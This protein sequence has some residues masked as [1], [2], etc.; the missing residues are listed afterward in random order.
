MYDLLLNIHRSSWYRYVAFVVLIL[1]SSCFGFN[2]DK[3]NKEKSKD[4]EPVNFTL[5]QI[6]KR[7]TLIALVNN[8]STSYFLY[9][10]HPRGFQYDL[11][12]RFA[13][14]VGVKL[15]LKIVNNVGDAIKML[16]NGEGDIIAS[17]IIITKD[18][19]KNLSFTDPLYNVKQVLVQR[20]PE[21]YYNMEKHQIRSYL[22][23]NTIELVG[24]KVHVKKN[25]AYEDRLV[26]LSEEVGGEINIIKVDD[27]ITTEGLIEQVANNEID[28]TVADDD[29]AKV[30]ATY[31]PVL[32]I[33]TEIGLTQQVAWAV[34]KNNPELLKE[35]NDWLNKIKSE[36]TFN[37]IYRKYFKIEKRID[38][39]AESEYSTI[40][41]SNISPYDP[42]IKKAANEINWDWKLLSAQIYEES[43]FDPNEVSWMG[44]IGLMQVLPETAASYGSFNL[45]QP[46]QNIQAGIE[47]IKWLIDYWQPHI[48]DST[49]RVRFVLGS[50]NV[51]QGHVM[52]AV[53]LAEKY[54]RNPDKWND[55]V[56]YYLLQ[57]S[58]PEFYKDP[59]VERGYCRG[60]EPVNYVIDILLVYNRY[61]Q[62]LNN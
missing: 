36:P 12:K 53:R 28:Y 17:K 57:K 37:V 15:K 9:R 33:E 29:I 21:H 10:G 1:L 49:E 22:I 44:A 51:G 2:G 46:S 56:E 41:G 62:L 4:I 42:E 14:N 23:R 38:R 31:Y 34:R 61:Q 3:R 58:K 55:N 59:V 13:D 6:K 52:D 54:G 35:I 45:Y 25:T 48:S 32:D 8:S 16:N 24:K 60:E 26:N 7:D 19:R 47:H 39:R 43:K 18:R 11:L 5:D 20:K 50:Y 40:N 27:N 30:N